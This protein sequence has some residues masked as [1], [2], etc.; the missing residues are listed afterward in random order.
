MIGALRGSLPPI[1]MGPSVE[2]EARPGLEGG[3]ND[4]SITES[5]GGST[6]HTAVPLLGGAGTGRPW[7]REAGPGRREPILWTVRGAGA[8]PPR[9]T[10]THELGRS[11]RPRCSSA[12]RCEARGTS[13]PPGRPHLRGPTPRGPSFAGGERGDCCREA[14]AAPSPSSSH[15]PPVFPLSRLITAG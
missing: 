1:G 11:L 9:A 4:P 6:Y 15:A 12:F 3:A 2:E 5:A 10:Q 8:G 14:R 13:S 7:H